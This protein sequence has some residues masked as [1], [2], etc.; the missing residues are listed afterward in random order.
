MDL[1]PQ[2][3]PPAFPAFPTRRPHAR[4]KLLNSR[5]TQVAQ[6][7]VHVCLAQSRTH[8]QKCAY[9]IRLHTRILYSNNYS[10]F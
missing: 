4:T 7:R 8:L 5:A 1:G 10:N 2:I 9:S 6:R 3:A